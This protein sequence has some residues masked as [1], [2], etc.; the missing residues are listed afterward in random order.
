MLT[1]VKALSYDGMKGLLKSQ[2]ELLQ[3]HTFISVLPNALRVEEPGFVWP[4]NSDRWMSMFFEDIRPEHLE[5]LPRLEEEIGRRIERFTDDQADQLIQFLERAHA[6]AERECLYVNCVA[7]ISRSGAISSFVCEAY[8]L[9]RQAFW[10][11][12]PQIQPNS[13][14]L[15]LL[16]D[17]F[18]EYQKQGASFAR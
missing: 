12:N 2:P 8:K 10:R 11:D 3:A 4:Q 1:S 15:F 9:D 16:R 7:G 18:A 17:R 6:R 14:V 5:M 13:L